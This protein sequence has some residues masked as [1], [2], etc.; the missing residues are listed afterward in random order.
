ME[1]ETLRKSLLKERLSFDAERAAAKSCAIQRKFLE[2]ALYREAASVAVYCDFK[3]EVETGM[4]LEDVLK[5]EKL[6]ALPR[7]NRPGYT[8]SFLPVCSTDTLEV[9]RDG[10]REPA[11][12]SGKELD[13]KEIDL[14]VLPGVAYDMAGNRLGMGKGCYDKALENIGREKMVALAYEFQVIETVPAERHDARVGWIVT[15]ERLIRC[16]P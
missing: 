10:F 5:G 8:L 1:K 3:G 9:N 11:E 14:F 13:V 2:S 7:I 6:L 12:G 4:I 16:K 15:E